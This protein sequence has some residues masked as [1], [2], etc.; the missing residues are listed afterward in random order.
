[1]KKTISLMLLIYF[2]IVSTTSLS[3]GKE[4]KEQRENSPKDFRYP[5]SLW[6][7]IVGGLVGLSAGGYLVTIFT[8]NI[9]SQLWMSLLGLEYGMREGF[10]LGYEDG[11]KIQRK[12]LSD[13]FANRDAKRKT[14]FEVNSVWLRSVNQNHSG[15]TGFE[16][17]LKYR[18]GKGLYLNTSILLFDTR[19]KSPDIP[20][21]GYSLGSCVN[22]LSLGSL[23]VGMSKDLNFLLPATFDFDILYVFVVNKL[24]DSLVDDY[25]TF[26]GF[27]TEKIENDMAFQLEYG[28][29]IINRVTFNIGYIQFI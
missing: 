26:G 20:Y 29:I 12:S 21:E 9:W 25:T 16:S 18:T 19:Y 7:G 27:V 3:W 1:M 28:V 4:Y 17:R 13:I 10:R 8:D 6:G 14:L 2:F 23:G 22:K 5:G 11:K 24:S 15:G